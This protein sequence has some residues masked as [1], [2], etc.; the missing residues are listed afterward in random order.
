MRELVGVVVAFLLI[1]GIMLLIVRGLFARETTHV[2]GRVRQREEELQANADLL[3]QRLAQ[4]EQDHR[5]KL[6]HAQAEAERMLQ[7]A[8]QQASNIRTA[9]VEE[10][11]Y[12]ARQLVMES[13]QTRQQM[14]SDLRRE[15][16]DQAVAWTCTAIQT[17][18]TAPEQESLHARLLHHLTQACAQVELGHVNGGLE[19]I[20]V[21]SAKP[22]AAEQTEA[23]QRCL[24]TKLNHPV[25]LDEMTDA[26]LI[27]GGVVSLGDVVVDGS[28]KQ[29]LTR[30]AHLT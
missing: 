16:H 18:L 14:V 19:R 9:A 24:S 20:P 2:L 23:L 28:L 4:T 26:G 13:E 3:E 25:A 17:L 10:A 7:E 22:L 8:K 21:R 30:L 29:Y 11:K 15:L 5:L 27:A 6:K 12:R 1:V